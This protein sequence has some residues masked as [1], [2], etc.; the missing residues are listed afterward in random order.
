[1]SF[2]PLYGRSVLVVEDEA[3]IALDI[4]DGLTQRGARVVV[5][6]SV[7]GAIGY[8]NEGGISAAVIDRAL[9]DGFCTPICQR[10]NERAIPFIM[11]SGYGDLDVPCLSGVHFPKPANTSDIADAIVGFFAD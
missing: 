3:L 6:A 5:T 10:L 9:R 7:E 8:I 11:H 1:M 4:A 2:A